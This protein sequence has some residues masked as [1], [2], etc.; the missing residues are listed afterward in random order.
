VSK[1]N[2]AA[3]KHT[4][5]T[6]TRTCKIVLSTLL[7]VSK[8]SGTL[9]PNNNPSISSTS[10]RRAFFESCTSIA[11]PY[12]HSNNLSDKM[13]GQQLDMLITEQVF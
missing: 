2:F 12:I 11:P 5:L 9:P 4:I 3:H 8:A 1:Q 13:E 6:D 10:F 7:T